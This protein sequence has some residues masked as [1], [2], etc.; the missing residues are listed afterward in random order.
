[1]E[2]ETHTVA[3][4]GPTFGRGYVGAAVAALSSWLRANVTR[5][6]LG[7]FVTALV[8]AL[9]TLYIVLL[10]RASPALPAAWAR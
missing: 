9:L 5:I 6:L 3:T 2:G 10:S 1:V 4:P 8:L 7:G